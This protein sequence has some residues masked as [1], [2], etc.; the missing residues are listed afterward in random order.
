MA[1]SHDLIVAVV[2]WW[3]AYLLRFN[4]DVPLNYM[5][6]MQQTLPWVVFVQVLAFFLFGLY[7]GIWRYASL[8]DLRRILF[9]VLAAMAVVPLMLFFLQILIGVPRSILLLDPI[10]LLLM[11]GGSRL[12]YRIWNEGQLFGLKNSQGTHVL[13][14]GSG[15]AAI[16]LIKDLSRSLEWSVVGLLDDDPSKHRL[17]LHGSKVLGRI[18]ELPK[19]AKKLGVNHAIIAMPSANHSARRRALDM[20]AVAKIKALT[21]PSYDDLV[22]GKVTVSQVRKVELDDLLGRD[23]ILLDSAGLQGLL[24]GKTVLVTGAGGSVGSELCRQIVKFSPASLVLFELSELALYNIEQEFRNNFPNIS[25]AFVIGD[26]KSSARLKQVFLKFRPTIIFHAAAYKHVPLMEQENSWQAILNNVLGTY[27]LAQAAVKYGVERFIL[28]STDKAVNPTNVM[29]ASKRLAEMVCQAQQQAIS[30]GRNGYENRSEICFVIVRFGNVLGSAGSVIPKFYEQIAKGGPITVTH[31]KIMRYFMSITEAAQLVLQAGL[32]GGES[33][34]GEIFVLDMGKPVKISDLAKDLI[35]LSGF[36]EED[37]DIVYSGLRPGEKLY[38]EL[39]AK[40]EDILPTHHPKL[41]IAKGRKVE[42]V[43]LKDLLVWLN[44]SS[45]LSDDL[46]K[47]GLV[48]LVPEYSSKD[49]ESDQ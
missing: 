4:F 30:A 1:V 9:A 36:S 27:V 7:R 23:Q 38:E 43:L 24:T 11:M 14:L 48:K 47:Q 45:A 25:M 21:V 39:L 19:L 49:Y 37:I 31:P 6:S 8:P 2:A 46:V 32:M 40:D 20:C 17:I 26:I 12:I 35:R 22:S 13:I 44:Q 42:V 5:V 18:E 33:S 3:L 28:I 10:L 41:S 15:D 34:G 29:G 16:S